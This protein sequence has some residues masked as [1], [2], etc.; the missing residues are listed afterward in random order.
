M[1]ISQAARTLFNCSARTCVNP[2]TIVVTMHAKGTCVCS[3]SRLPTVATLQSPNKAER[4]REKN[5]PE[6]YKTTKTK[7][8]TLQVSNVR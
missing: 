7:I 5:A 4:E 3:S 8:I 2:Q 1:L 6:L